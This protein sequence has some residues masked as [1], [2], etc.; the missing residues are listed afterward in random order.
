MSA[1]GRTLKFKI[2]LSLALTLTAAMTAFTLFVVEHQRSEL[3]TAATLH[4]ADI[5]E[6]V[7]KSTRYAMLK[8]DHDYVRRI[9]QDIGKQKN[10]AKV[11]IWNKDGKI[12]YSSHAAEIDQPLDR[13]ADGCELCYPNALPG[14]RIPEKATSRSFF[15]PDGRRMIGSTEVLQNEVSCYSASCHEH[16][17]ADPV[18][19]VLDIVYS[20]DAI[21]RQMTDHAVIMFGSSLAFIVAVSL[22]VGGFVSRLVYRPLKDLEGGAER[23]ASGDLKQPI[24]VRSHDEF[25]HVAESFNAMTQALQESQGELRT[26]GLT[27]EQKVEERTRELGAAVAETARSEKLAAVGLL[28]AGVAH[29]LNNPLTGVLTFSYLLRE[30]VPDGSQEAED[31]DLVIRETKRCAGIIRRLLDFARDK[32]PERKYA[33]LNRI[34]EN[35]ARIVAQQASLA[36]IEVALELDP[37]LPP[38]WIDADF[39]EQVIL[40]M[41][42]NAQHAI[43]NGGRIAVTT[44]EI[45]AA[46]D[47][48]PDEAALTMVE[49]AIADNGC[50]IAAADLQRIFDPFFTTKEVGKGTGLGLS[51]SHGI[52]NSHGGTIEVEST[53]GVGSTFRVRLPLEAR[54][55]PR[56]QGRSEQ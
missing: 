37:E 39:V 43:G 20:V 41:L 52:V 4:L 48:T 10:I 8:D 32:K 31:L 15:A 27:M 38:L 44:R 56:E 55:T 23:L 28:A 22:L 50:G 25:G 33:D 17:K 2:G 21:D 19:G 24:P 7:T 11:R 46:P 26:W 18:L 42:V 54:K 14:D 35:T 5:S 51:V 1:R 29:E 6:L 16:K 49:I 13:T 12:V 47:A 3:R 40:N 45:A 30:K 34:I 36:D 53:V 9:V